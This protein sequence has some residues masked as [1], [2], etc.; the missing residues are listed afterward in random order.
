[1][2][3]RFHPAK[4]ILASL[5][6]SSMLTQLDLNLATMQNCQPVYEAGERDNQEVAWAEFSTLS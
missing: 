6:C 2:G 4:K 1:M 5:S 3:Q